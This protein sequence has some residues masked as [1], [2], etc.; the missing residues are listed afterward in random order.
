M[1]NII[2]TTILSAAVL[3]GAAS[4]DDFLTVDPEDSLVRDNYYTSADMVRANTRSLYGCY[5]WYNFTQNF[6]WKLDELVGDMY[7]TY[8][9][10]GQWF[11]GTY[12]NGNPYLN[13]G[14]KGLY[15]I[16]ALANSIISD[17]PGSASKSGVSDAAIQQGLA[18]ARC[19]RGIVY[20]L[21][22]ETWQN[23]PIITNNS[24][25]IASGNIQSPRHTQ[26]S[27][28]EFIKSDLEF[29]ASVLKESDAEEGRVTKWTALGMLAK[30][31]VTMASHTDYGYDREALYTSAAAHAKQVME[32]IKTQPK[33]LDYG[34]LFYPESNNGPESLFAIQCMVYGYGYGNPRTVAWSRTNI[35]DGSWGDGKGPTIGLQKLYDQQDKR[36]YHTF[37]QLNDY[38]PNLCV[39]DGGYT[40]KIVHYAADGTVDKERIPLNSHLRKYILGKSADCN[41]QVGPSQDAA[42]NIYILRLSDVYMLYAEALMG[43]ASSTTNEA[44]I[45]AVDNIRERAGLGTI[46]SPLT[47]ENLLKERRREFAME[48]NN[49]FDI[50]RLAYREGKER[51]LAYLNANNGYNRNMVYQ[52]KDGTPNSD[53]GMNNLDNY[54]M[55]LENDNEIIL[56]ISCFELPVPAAALTN[57]PQLADAPVDYEF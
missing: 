38:Y 23:V 9:Q 18:E 7:Y 52:V 40:Y 57:S 35:A 34:T 27:V 2:K 5:Q 37:M 50:Q 6:Q 48:S 31:E 45:K 36:R 29:A 54:T 51:A 14:W 22:A 47:Y 3:L 20:Y 56:P 15:N 49:W 25:M 28:Y 43:T 55:T 11:Y 12:T 33:E 10:E 41:N 46:G 42:N 30:L 17:M 32:G 21:L 39:S 19:I 53:A 1:K 24:E 8:D 44:A 16:V 4:C 13:E 26:K